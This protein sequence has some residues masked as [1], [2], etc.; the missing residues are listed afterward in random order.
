MRKKNYVY[1]FLILILAVTMASCTSAPEMTNSGSMSFADLSKRVNENAGK[2][3]SLNAEGEISI[4]SPTLSNTGSLTVSINRPDS[5][6]TK[7]EGPFG[8]DIADVL[9]TRNEFT[10][11]NATEN[12][13]IRGPSTQ[14]NLG[15][16]LKMKVEFDDL[17]NALSGSFMIT[18]K[19]TSDYKI[20]RSEDN[21]LLEQKAGAS[22]NR[23]WINAEDFYITR[24]QSY[25][26]GGKLKLEITYEEFYESDGIYFPK[27]ITLTRPKEKQYVWVTYKIENLNPGKLNYRLKIPGSAKKVQW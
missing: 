1:N 18:N 14:R 19:D 15:I 23:Y 16:I 6:Y 4:D 26:T 25:D 11:Y 8:I 17:L 5:L 9:V 21:Y 2:L 20:L 10:Y 27:K 22:T 12:K 13:V 3:L 7:I 24:I